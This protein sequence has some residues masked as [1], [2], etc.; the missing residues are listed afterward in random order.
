MNR[1]K[2]QENHG[3]GSISPDG[4]S[5]TGIHPISGVGAAAHGP[6]ERRRQQLPAEADPEHRHPERDR[7]PRE[8]DLVADPA[9]DRGRVVHRPGRAEEHD[10]VEQVGRR[11]ER[12]NVGR[13]VTRLGDDGQ[14]ELVPP[15]RG[16]R[17]P[18]QPAGRGVILLNEE[19]SHSCEDNGALTIVEDPVGQ[20]EQ[21]EQPLDVEEER[22][23]AD[24]PAADL[25]HKQRPGREPAALPGP[26]CTGPRRARRW[27]APARA[28][29]PR[30]RSAPA[31]PSRS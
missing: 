9:P 13:L 19:N 6:A 7:R 10:R 29:T 18:D 28:A 15:E 20:P 12:R 21:R 24:L 5:E 11:E 14:L 27:P 8:R 31:G 17:V 4:S 16:E 23:P 30:R 26:A 25:M 1:S 3:P 2:C 22:H